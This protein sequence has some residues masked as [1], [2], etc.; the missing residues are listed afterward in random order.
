MAT[1]ITESNLL[2]SGFL[3]VQTASEFLGRNWK[4]HKFTSKLKQTSGIYVDK[5]TIK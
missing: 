2:N 4:V 5:T 3:P 1:N